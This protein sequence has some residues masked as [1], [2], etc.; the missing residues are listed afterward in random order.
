MFSY[1]VRRLIAAVLIVFAASY[2]IY[3]LAANA[4]DPLEELRQSTAP[5]K[6]ALIA[7]KT[8][9]LNLDVPPYLRYF[10]WLGGVLKGF[11][12]NLDLGYNIRGQEVAAQ[13]GIGIGQTVQL[14]VIA[15]VLSIL[16]GISIG[17]ATALRQYSGFDYSVT[18]IAFVFFSLP[19]FWVA[20]IL[21]MYVAI[22]FNNFLADPEVAPW[23]I[24]VTSLLLGFAWASIV[25]GAAKKYF[26]NFGVA[27]V[28]TAV[29][30]FFILY[31]GW[32]DTPSLGIIGVLGI[33]VAAAFALVWVTAGFS[34]RKVIYTA[35]VT[36]VAGAALWYPFNYLF[37]YLPSYLSWLIVLVVM[38]AIAVGAAFIFGGDERPSSI[39][40]GVLTAIIS[41]I[42]IIVDRV[43]GSWPDYVQ[44]TN[45]RPIA[46]IGSSTP[47]LDGSV[48][49]ETI[50]SFTHLLL[51]TMALMLLSLAAWSRYSRGSLLE[52]MNQDYVRTA[53]AKGL[54][55]R[56]VIMRHAFRNA[57][58][59]ITTL[60]AFEIGGIIGGAAITE[61][62]FGWN[63]VGRMFIEA[64]QQVDLNTIMAVFLI[65]SIVTIVFNLIAD[66]TYSA[67]DPRIRV[68]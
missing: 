12:G 19:V 45:G 14:V 36:A 22:G 61:T 31:T 47:N 2:L 1:I 4:G 62:I 30:L 20:Q 56:T 43:M 57:M 38:V 26:L 50:D 34:D 11:T 46:T 58:I 27:T 37:F 7:A 55:E 3:I 6:D 39:R 40:A 51:P 24:I 60:I 49:I 35:L 64:V 67:L 53:R 5:N 66:L 54:S 32:L 29:G 8:A 18:F 10:I 16:L 44:I 41:S 59:P 52:V 28:V 21:K 9:Q 48:W 68:N 33:G 23:I 42:L 65:T 17:M 25:G 63:G 15:T 13:V